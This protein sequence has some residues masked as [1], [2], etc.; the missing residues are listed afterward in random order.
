MRLY[1]VSAGRILLDG[2][3]IKKYQV[4]QYR[5]L[6]SMVQ[7]EPLLFST[8]IRENI[9]YG[10]TDSSEKE[11]MEAARAANADQFILNLEK[12][13]DTEVG[14]RGMQLSGGERQRISIARAYLKNAPILILDEPTSS[15]D[16]RTEATIMDALERLMTGRTTFLITHKLDTLEQCDALLHLED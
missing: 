11:I 9:A 2:I 7:Q 13:Y 5:S 12:G 6:F 15:V 14:E 8:S 10:K 3:N 4:A 1:D 16:I